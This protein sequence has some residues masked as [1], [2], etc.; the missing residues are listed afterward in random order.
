MLKRRPSNG[1]Q[2]NSS[3]AFLE[4]Q[5]W[6]VGG[7][8]DPHPRRPGSRPSEARGRRTSPAVRRAVRR[9]GWPHQAALVGSGVKGRQQCLQS[10]H[11]GTGIEDRVGKF[12]VD[13]QLEWSELTKATR[14]ERIPPK[15]HQSGRDG[16]AGSPSSVRRVPARHVPDRTRDNGRRVRPSR[17]NHPPDSYRQA[18]NRVRSSDAR[19]EMAPAAAPAPTARN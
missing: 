18:G 6:G 7:R 14:P 4:S 12:V 2:R 5:V 11:A 19:C 17:E 9:S 15:A 3:W 10:R 8:R 13:R 1:L 16:S